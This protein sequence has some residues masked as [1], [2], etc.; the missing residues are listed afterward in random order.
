[1]NLKKEESFINNMLYKKEGNEQIKSEILKL[2]KYLKANVL[3]DKE[4][5]H[6]FFLLG[7]LYIKLDNYDSAKTYFNNACMYDNS[8]R[9]ALAVLAKINLLNE[10]Y[11]NAS[12]NVNDL[13][14]LLADDEVNCLENKTSISIVNAL[15]D[16]VYNKKNNLNTSIKIDNYTKKENITY[17]T[18]IKY[19]IGE[20]YEKALKLL[21]SNSAIYLYGHMTILISKI[22]LLTKEKTFNI[23][24]IKNLFK[25]KE[26][27]LATK[28]L[29]NMYDKKKIDEDKLIY[30]CKQLIDNNEFSNAYLII[31]Q[32]KAKGIGY[33]AGML[34]RKYNESI[35]YY[36]LNSM[37]KNDIKLLV[38]KS[39]QEIKKENYQNALNYLLCGL[40]YTKENIFNYY[41]GKLYFKCFKDYKT[42]EKY[43]KEYE[44]SGYGKLNKSEFFLTVIS[45]KTNG[46]YNKYYNNYIKISKYMDEMNKEDVIRCVSYLDHAIDY[47]NKT[48]EQYYFGKKPSKYI[49]ISEEDF[50]KGN[51]KKI[52]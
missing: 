14:K 29:I 20:K 37:V 42:A 21:E 52:I 11:N 8:N 43:F 1:M 31:K 51:Q 44:K 48:K 4:S 5:S 6:V 28:T 26:Y 18:L 19:I 17:S 12:Q 27:V 32:L 50:Q 3:S 30:Y 23:E 39:K 15:L 33:E 25:N 13:T 45:I 41:I 34:E 47:K 22:I 24:E 36:K 49:D 9:R 40:E 2:N 35:H 16:I 10:E 46:K 38:E 7:K